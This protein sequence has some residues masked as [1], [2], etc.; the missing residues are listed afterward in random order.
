M[1]SKIL[2]TSKG[3]ELYLIKVCQE[4]SGVFYRQQTPVNPVV[5]TGSLELI[6]KPL[7]GCK[8]YLVCQIT[9]L[10]RGVPYRYALSQKQ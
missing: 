1:L 9:V 6:S 7:Y 2:V 8:P 3:F 5:S 10:L 4:E